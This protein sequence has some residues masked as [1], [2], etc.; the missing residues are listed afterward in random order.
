VVSGPDRRKN[1]EAMKAK[2]SLL[3]GIGLLAAFA[4]VWLA[5]NQPAH[6]PT[7]PGPLLTLLVGAS[8]LGS[9][10]ASW[11]ARPDNRLGP[12]MVLTGFAWFA[13]QLTE[14]SNS[15]LYTAGAAVQYVFIAGFVYQLLS[16]PSGRLER[17]LDRALVWLTIALTVGVTLVAM[18]YGN[19]TGLRCGTC[20]DNLL[21]VFDNNTRAHR[22]LDVQR[23][24]GG[25]VILTTIVALVWRWWRASAAQRR[26]VAPV[27]VAGTATLVA[28]NWTIVDDLLGTP[29]NAL[30]ATVFFYVSATV[31]VSV[32]VVFLQRRLARGGVAGLVVQLGEPSAFANLRE[33]L[34][35][36][37]GDPSLELA[38]WFAAESRYVGGD[39]RTVELPDADSERQSTFVEREGQ[40][41]AVLL[42]DSVLQHNAELV[43]SVCAAAGLA[44]ENERLQAELRA[45]LVELQESRARLVEATD[46]ERRRIERDLHDGTQQRLVSIA[47]SLGLLEAKLPAQAAA[48]RPLVHETRESLALALQELRELSHGIH[49]PLLAEQGLAAA[50][51][52]LCRRAALPTRLDTALDKRLPDRVESAAYFVASEA[53]T[54]AAKHSHGTEVLIVASC[55]GET[56]TVDVT[57]DGIG[58]ASAAGGSG[59]RGLADRVEA[60]GGRLTLSSPPGRGTTVCAEIP[61]A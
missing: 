17:R 18:L 23:V 60:L 54:N 47:M 30:P 28:L 8:L 33:A 12:V 45:R 53:L 29:L 52:D 4:A 61:C 42:H 27:L 49:P 55:D 21:R 9:G 51:D 20:P 37:L 31:P 16:F 46:A 44:L 1:P 40:P 57:D 25:V 10:L 59:L 5:A 14:A 56:L 3:A 41:I 24:L 36:A 48:A 11:Q 7:E 43:R 32:L 58:G 50:L 6:R 19:K 38:F 26:A 35:R 34:A 13:G 39:G 22:L 15:L 2:L